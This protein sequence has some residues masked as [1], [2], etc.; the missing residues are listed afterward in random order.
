MVQ[1]Y[2]DLKIKQQGLVVPVLSRIGNVIYHVPRIKHL[3]L[4][5]GYMLKPFV[6]HLHT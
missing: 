3:T 2:T 4:F 1:V 5:G 6:E